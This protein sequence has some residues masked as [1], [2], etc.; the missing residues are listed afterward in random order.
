MN[1]PKSYYRKTLNNFNKENIFYKYFSIEKTYLEGLNY[2]KKIISFFLKRNITKKNIYLSCDKSFEMYVTIF[3]ILLTN[4]TWIPLSKSLPNNRI[5]NILREVPPDVFIHDKKDIDK[6]SL[7]RK[8]NTECIEYRKIN[9]LRPSVNFEYLNNLINKI[10][11]CETALIYFTS[12]STG[13]PKGIKISHKNIISNIHAQIHHLFKKKYFHK[14]PLIFGD[15]YD[16]AFSIFFGIYF[17]AINLGATISPGI[18]KSDLF[19]PF[20]HIKKNKVNILVA[21]PSMMQRIKD[22][23]QD[24]KIQ[25]KFNIIIMVGEPF[26]LSLLKYVYKNLDF[27]KLFNCYGGTELSYAVYYHVCRKTDLINYKKFNL[28]PIGK[29]YRSVKSKIINNVLVVSGPMVALGYI[30]AKLNKGKFI[31]KKN[32]TEY[33]T[34][35]IVEKKNGIMICKGRKDNRVKIRGYRI[36]IPYVESMI[37][38]LEEIDQAIVLEKKETDYKNYLL[39]I[40][41]LNRT[42]SEIKVREKISKE[43]PNY[44]VPKK[45]IFRKS[46]P[47]NSNGKLN[48]N[49]M[50]QK[51]AS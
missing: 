37:L 14:Y 45:I 44:M 48:R 46:M 34:G 21:V 8:F 3:G 47:L 49:L 31:F 7:F 17:P 38:K 40:I 9:L 42:I 25:H 12:G 50:K 22:Y 36:E 39:A 16:T 2:L 27:K 28:V 18:Q 20:N 35:D 24:K 10:N 26:Y 41:K 29:K 19:L 6:I 15:Y 51:Y 5:E 11:F 13:E 43:V 32:V 23:Y 30:N 4:N 33:N 1:S